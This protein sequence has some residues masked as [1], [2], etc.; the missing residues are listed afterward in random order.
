MNIEEIPYVAK[1]YDVIMRDDTVFN[2]IKKKYPEL[3]VDLLS[4]RENP[5][6]ECKQRVINYLTIKLN[7]KEDEAFLT[8]LIDSDNIKK[9]REEVNEN[10]KFIIEQETHK[11]QNMSLEFSTPGKIY[12]VEKNDEAWLEFVTKIKASLMFQA[13]SVVDK[14]THL[15]VY[16][17]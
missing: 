11:Q 12:K 2:E 3:G 17:V 10:W 8:R 4:S 5:N 14:E 7:I 9:L 15:E 13:F 1:Y 6:C 16:F